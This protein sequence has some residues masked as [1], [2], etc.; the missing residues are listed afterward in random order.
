V[1]RLL[2]AALA[3]VRRGWAVFPCERGGKRPLGRLVPHGLKDATADPERV[4]AWWTEEPEANVAIATGAP[5]GLFV[6]DLDGPQGEDSYGVLLVDHQA[7]CFGPRPD[8]ATVRTPGGGWHLYARLEAGHRVPN[9]AGR[10]APGL[11]VRGDGG[12]VVAPPSVH[13]SGGRYVWVEPPGGPLPAPR[14]WIVEAAAPPRPDVLERPVGPLRRRAEGGSRYGIAAC[15]RELEMLLEAREGERNHRL[16]RAAF[17]LGQLVGGG[18][19]PEEGTRLALL[20]IALA[21]GLGQHESE[22]TIASGM[23]AGG[24]WPR[25]APDQAAA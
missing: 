9:S 23:S 1:T 10:I 14:P 12:Y 7:L 19:L 8:G 4:R 3:Y 17:S 5:S 25:I 22:L 24:E 2:D 21:I 20:E 6:V 11:D 15:Q 18:E 16:N 13:P